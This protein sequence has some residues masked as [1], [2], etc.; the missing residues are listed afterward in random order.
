MLAAWAEGYP[1]AI[2]RRDGLTF[3]EVILARGA[4]TM[5]GAKPKSIAEH[6]ADPVTEQIYHDI[7][8]TLRVTGVN[9]NFRTWAGFKKFFPRIWEALRPCAE[10]R[11]FEEAADLLRREAVLQAGA[12]HRLDAVSGRNYGAS[13]SHQIQAALD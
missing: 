3:G 5:L 9:L 1:A 6:E 7:R 12:F 10:T 2:V 11:A 4:A 13:R 8:Q